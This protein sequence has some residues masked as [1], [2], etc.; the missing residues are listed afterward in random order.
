M[1]FSSESEINEALCNNIIKIAFTQIKIIKTAL[2][3]IL[4]LFI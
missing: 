1:L 3:P 4:C 2:A